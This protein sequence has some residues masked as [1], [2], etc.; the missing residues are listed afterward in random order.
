MWQRAGRC[1]TEVAKGVCK[2][3]ATHGSRRRWSEYRTIVELRG[4]SEAESGH[5]S[6]RLKLIRTI[7]QQEGRVGTRRSGIIDIGLVGYL[8]TRCRCGNADQMAQLLDLKLM[9]EEY[10]Y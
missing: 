8:S 1:D 2:A 6:F 9:D 5:G 10:V 7:G 4:R 3:A